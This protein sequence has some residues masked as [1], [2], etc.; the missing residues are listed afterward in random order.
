MLNHKITNIVKPKII[1]SIIIS[2]MISLFMGAVVSVATGLNFGAVS[3]GLIALSLIPQNIPAGALGMA[4]NKEIWVDYIIGNLFK[5]NE[6]L[7]YAIDESQYVLQGSVVHIPQAGSPSGVKRNRKNLPATVTLRSDSDITYVLDEFTTDPRLIRDAEKVELSYDKIASVLSEDMMYLRQIIAEWMLYKWA[8]RVFINA[9]GTATAA[10]IT[11]ATGNRTT[12]TLQD[13]INAK[14]QMNKDDV[15]FEERFALIDTTM[16][17]QLSADLKA[18]ST[19]D[20]SV[21]YDPATGNIKKL[22]GFTLI[23]RSSALVTSTGTSG[24][25]Y[26]PD[27]AIAATACGV[28]LCWQ[29]ASV[30]KALGDVKMF[31]EV[32]SPTYY[33][34]LYSF[35]SRMGGRVRRAD[36]KGILGI[37]QVAA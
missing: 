20:Y 23:E 35:L 11:G 25:I 36:N 15:P 14:V 29:K 19:R 9:S 22:E 2:V 32:D 21:V 26:S 34:D 30:A 28:A 31:D 37:R 33:G 16:M 24:V 6:F 3:L 8:P 17:N 27:D 5:N 1:L 13:L 12:L 4:V 18:T 7:N 10:H